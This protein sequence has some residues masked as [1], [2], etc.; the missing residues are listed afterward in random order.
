MGNAS[1]WKSGVTTAI[2]IGLVLG[3]QAQAT[4]AEATFGFSGWAV[5]YLPT[6]IAIDR[7]NELGHEIEVVELGGNPNQLQA[8]ATGAIDITVLAQ[9]MDAIDQGFDSRMFMAANTNEFLMVGRA[10]IESCEDLAGK[11]VAIHSVGS[12]VGQLAIQWMAADCPEIDANMTVIEG[13]ENRLAALLADQIDASPVDLQDWTLLQQAAPG[14]FTVVEDFTKSVPILRAAFGAQQS[15][16][17]ENPELIRDWISVHL[18]VYEEIYENPTLLVEK[19][20]ELLGEI[21]PEVLPNIVD[22][23]LTARV[24]PTDGGLS[25]ESVQETIDFFNNDGEPYANITSPKDV[26]D[27]T[28]LDEVLSSR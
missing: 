27:R 14:K 6:A 22:T 1:K 28:I 24:W 12:F 9:V 16:I 18:D 15:F 13:S 23:F 4:A 17:K 11:D 20:K 26:I 10:G 7:L 19:G 25:E 3:V 8:A 21:N 5:G 2:A